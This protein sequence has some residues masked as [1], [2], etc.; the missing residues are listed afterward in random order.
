M[1]AQ[2]EHDFPEDYNPPARTATVYLAMGR[3]DEALG[4]VKRAIF[5]AYG[6]RKL[7]LLALLADV[8]EAKGDKASARGA[9]QTALD[10]ARAVPLV[11]RYAKLRDTLAE[12]WATMR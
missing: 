9:L 7:L 10:F 6:P 3:Y 11:A 2:S 1:L 12:R 8:Y 5:R 4:A